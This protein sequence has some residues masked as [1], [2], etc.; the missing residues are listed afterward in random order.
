MVEESSCP[1]EWHSGDFRKLPLPCLM[2]II[3]FISSFRSASL[4][5]VRLTLKRL[6]NSLSVGS[7][8][9]GCNSPFKKYFCI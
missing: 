7:F 8:S 4:T 2:S 9:P 3:P 1:S 6:A 5:E